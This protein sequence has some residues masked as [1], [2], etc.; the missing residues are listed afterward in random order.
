MP[1]P[2]TNPLTYCGNV[3]PVRCFADLLR[4][5]PGE[6]NEV[7]RNA[8]WGRPFDL[9][10]W[11]PRAAL[12]EALEPAN[13]E[14]L[15]VT[16]E[17]A[18]MRVATWNG[19][20]Y[21]VFHGEPVKTRVYRPDWSE[22]DRLD[23]TLEIA[24]LAA[25]LGMKRAPIST[26]SGGFKPE[27]TP[28]KR[29][30]YFA[31]LL[32]FAREAARLEDETGCCCELALEPE[33]FNTLEDEDD[34]VRFF[35]ELRQRARA[36]GLAEEARRH[37]GVCFD[38]CHFSVR[39]RDPRRAWRR[40]AEN[41]VPVPKVQVSVAPRW[42]QDMELEARA[43]FFAMD[44]PVYL[45]QTY[46]R[47]GTSVQAFLDLPQAGAT[48]TAGAKAGA[49]VEEWRTHFHVPVHWGEAADTTGFELRALLAEIRRDA[50]AGVLEVE[51]YSFAS[52][53]AAHR[54]E[55]VPLA[56]SIAREL[57]WLK[58]QMGG[59]TRPGALPIQNAP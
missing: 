54:R 50:Y 5:I 25:C 2:T 30:V 20:P 52:L 18:G 41:G 14:T 38:A 39:F 17:A 15:A 40:L 24:R 22:R 7:A 45:H 42:T 21:G 26:L 4:I 13:T 55:N 37:L 1:T 9:G 43:R 27:D 46:G 57:N 8:G 58:G 31:Q 12:R 59:E 44:E 53:Q 49:E 36:L 47:T 34:G 29:A 23:Y 19:F 3:H 6:F 51:T 11:L 10:L 35:E 33:P 32:E 56:E 48:C 16:L 28:E